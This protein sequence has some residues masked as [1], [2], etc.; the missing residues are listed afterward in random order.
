MIDRQEIPLLAY[1]VYYTLLVV[2]AYPASWWFVFCMEHAIIHIRRT[3]GRAPED[4][5]P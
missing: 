2:L 4:Y 3:L 5:S 1:V